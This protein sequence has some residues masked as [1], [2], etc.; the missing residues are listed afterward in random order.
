[1]VAAQILRITRTSML[2]VLNQDY[3]RT[4]RGIRSE[5]PN[6]ILASFE[7][8]LILCC[9]GSGIQLGLSAWWNHSNREYVC[10]SGMGRL[11]SGC[12]ERDYP[13]FRE[14][15]FYRDNNSNVEYLG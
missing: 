13:L 10:S 3:V 14:L 15:F 6:V 12:H 9:N 4:A 5:C 11:S 7:N 2:D 8:A 1:M